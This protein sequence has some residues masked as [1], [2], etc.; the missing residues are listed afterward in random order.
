MEEDGC[1][2]LAQPTTLTHTRSSS[3]AVGEAFFGVR[4]DTKPGTPLRHGIDRAALSVQAANDRTQD[5]QRGS[6]AWGGSS[7]VREGVLLPKP[8]SL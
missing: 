1:P 8:E 5:I 4:R 3:V 2:P 6:F 7:F